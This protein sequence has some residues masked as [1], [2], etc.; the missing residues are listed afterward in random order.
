MTVLIEAAFA[1]QMIDSQKERSMTN[2]I[3]KSLSART[4]GRL[5]T[6][7][8]LIALSGCGP[9]VVPTTSHPPLSADQVK[10]YPK[11]PDKYE[12]LGTLSVPI[13]AQVHWD[14]K[15]NADPASSS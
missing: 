6:A 5:V 9:T 10:I 1:S 15:G 4:V 2:S 7:M 13:S 8:C 11:A 14:E 12:I 3:M